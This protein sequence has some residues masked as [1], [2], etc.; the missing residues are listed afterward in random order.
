M[1]KQEAIEVIENVELSYD[2]D[3]RQASDAFEIAIECIQKCI[4]EEIKG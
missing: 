4:D 3:V 1:T 2:S